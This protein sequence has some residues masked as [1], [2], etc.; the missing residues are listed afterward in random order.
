[1]KTLA[2]LFPPSTPQLTNPILQKDLKLKQVFISGPLLS[3]QIIHL[4]FANTHD[5]LFITHDSAFLTALNG[6]R[7]AF[8]AEETGRGRHIQTAS[9]CQ[10]KYCPTSRHLRAVIATTPPECFVII[11]DIIGMHSHLPL[12]S[13]SLVKSLGLIRHALSHVVIIDETDMDMS[14]ATTLTASIPLYKLIQRIFSHFIRIQGDSND[15]QIMT[16]HNTAISEP[17]IKVMYSWE[18]VPGRGQ[19]LACTLLDVSTIEPGF[20]Q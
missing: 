6:A 9:R 16:L 3:S 1:M 2:D 15:T 13:T 8:C 11:H 5:I 19:Y 20:S 10:V 18:V 12:M 4:I 17:L 7:D 14:M